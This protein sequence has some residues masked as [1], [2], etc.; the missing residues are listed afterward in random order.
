MITAL[1]AIILGIVEGITEYLPISSTGHLIV[2][3][4]ALGIEQ[5]DTA[6]AFDVV[7]QLGAVLAVIWFYRSELMEQIRMVASEPRVRRFWLNIAI[8]FLPA[9]GIGFLFHKKI[10]F[11]LFSPMTVATSL[12]IGGLVLWLV[13]QPGEEEGE[14]LGIYE[15]MPGH[16]LW[17][18]VAQVLSLVPGVSRSGSSIVGGM[19]R[20][21]DRQT[22]TAF[23]F[24]LAIPTLGAATLYEFIKEREVILTAANAMP[25]AVG[26][27]VSFVVSLVVM[28]W[29]LRY[30]ASH[31]FRVFAIYRV[32]AG[33]FILW[34]FWGVA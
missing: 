26:T 8:A 7:I 13:D 15:I 9:A 27:A 22:A 1:Q 3:T 32:L 14:P 18:G 19:L 24:F 20:G 33:A 34:W 29:L 10:K 16:A 31:S 28:G 30:L 25:F 17:I 2:A 4:R 11:F 5:S 23:S 12:I 6:D 21:L